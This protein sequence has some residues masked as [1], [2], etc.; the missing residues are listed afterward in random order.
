MCI[1]D[2]VVRLAQLDLY[3][4]T[5]LVRR[6]DNLADRGERGAGDAGD[7]VGPGLVALPGDQR[8]GL[9]DP[10][11]GEDRLVREQGPDLPYSPQPLV[12]DED[13]AAL[14]DVDLARAPV[15]GAER[16]DEVEVVDRDL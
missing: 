16:G 11:I 3:L 1:R 2:R 13:R 4:A 7:P 5:V 8:A 9:G 14:D 10:H 15:Q 6:G 12:D